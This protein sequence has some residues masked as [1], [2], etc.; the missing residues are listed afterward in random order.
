[1]MKGEK[2]REPEITGNDIE[3]AFAEFH[4]KQ[5]SASKDEESQ[6]LLSL[7]S[8]V[9]RGIRQQMKARKQAKR[10]MRS[11]S[12][13]E[14]KGKRIKPAAKKESEMCKRSETEVNHK[15]SNK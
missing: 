8:Y 15:T 4:K 3:R 7:F 14:P 9:L 12:V 13:V 1:M 5:A 2:S 11:P 10:V 6:D